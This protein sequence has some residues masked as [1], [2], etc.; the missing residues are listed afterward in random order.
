MIFKNPI[1]GEDLK[2]INSNTNR[3]EIE[4]YESSQHSDII[5]L[6]TDIRKELRTL[7]TYFALI[8]EQRLP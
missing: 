6:L 1:S 8:T 3:A 4:N 2:D 5:C 7:N